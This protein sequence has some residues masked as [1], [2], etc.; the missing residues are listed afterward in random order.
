MKA[1]NKYPMI[2]WA[3]V[4]LAVMNISTIATILYR[5][6][7]PEKLVA[8]SDQKQLEADSEKFS[9]RYFR[10]KLNLNRAQMDKFWNMNQVF[11]PKAKEITIELSEKRKLM[12]VEMAALKSDTIRLNA[13]SDSIGRLHGDLKKV[14]YRYYLD[15]KNLCDPEQQRKLEQL[16]GE[17]FAND[18]PMG[19][20]GNGGQRGRQQGRRFNN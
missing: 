1:E 18:A 2:I 10:D 12:L 3:I 20:P 7:Q 14:T 8:V 11:R 19:Y 16:F 13:L 4:I 5:K 9:G 15:I 6:Y 17:M